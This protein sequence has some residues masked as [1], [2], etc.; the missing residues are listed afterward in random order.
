MIVHA[1]PFTYY[2]TFR[3]MFWASIFIGYLSALALVIIKHGLN[4]ATLLKIGWLFFLLPLSFLLGAFATWLMRPC[5]K[6]VV[7]SQALLSRDWRG[8]MCSVN[9]ED[10]IRVKS[11]CLFCRR[12]LK[13]YF[14]KVYSKNLKRPIWILLDLRNQ[15][16]FI[17]AI[18]TLRPNSG[19]LAAM[20]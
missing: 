10:I 8:C 11:A 3:S 16:E 20:S 12:F 14:L 1:T 18:R 5:S 6:V 2:P 15:H 19:L 17:N 9:W 4:E 7:S 13:M